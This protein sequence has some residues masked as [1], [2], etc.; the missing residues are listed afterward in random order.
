MSS[1]IKA[2]PVFFTVFRYKNAGS[3]LIGG[4][5][6]A[7]GEKFFAPGGYNE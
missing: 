1:E 4:L 2:N 7:G 5:H 6:T 3:N